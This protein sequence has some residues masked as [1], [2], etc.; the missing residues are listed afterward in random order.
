MSG[1]GRPLSFLALGVQLAL[2]ARVYGRIKQAGE[3]RL[4]VTRERSRPPGSIAVLV[5]ALDDLRRLGACLRGLHGQGPAVAE[6]IVID[7]GSNDG[8]TDL[9]RAWEVRDRRI[10]LLEAPPLPGAGASTSIPAALA[11]GADA[12]TRDADWLLVIS[13][14]TRPR[15]GLGRSLLAHATRTGIDLISG[16]VPTPVASEL[17]AAMRASLEAA[18]RTRF[19]PDG[20]IAARPA[21]AQANSDCLLIKRNALADAG[22]FASLPAT[23]GWAME[24]ARRVAARGR[25]VGYAEQIG[26]IA[27]DP[28]G[29]AAAVR[30]AWDDAPIIK[31]AAPNRDGL[32]ALAE[33]GLVQVAPLPLALLLAY[34]GGAAGA[35]GKVNLLLLLARAGI[36]AAPRGERPST[37]TWLAP[38]ADFPV[39]AGIAARTFS[40]HRE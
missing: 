16:A 37:G 6:I 8:T 1:P 9:V 36:L 27:A 7:R 30:A 25:M 39:L 32:L 23:R 31:A 40:R 26:L 5:P 4:V 24:L 17:D 19:G 14:G 20:R 15:T 18:E 3:P 28:P 35:L 22:G 11:A 13:P 34:R 38:L 10:R 2:A 12:A 33:I 29:S 21:L